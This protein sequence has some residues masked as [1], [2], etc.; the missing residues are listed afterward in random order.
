MEKPKSVTATQLTMSIGTSIIG[1]GILAFPRITVEYVRTGAPMAAICAMLLMMCG[2][3]V[4]AY[5]GNQYRER[6]IFEYAD[7]LVGQWIGRLLLVCIG[8]YFL[9]LAALASREFGEVVVTSVLQRTPIEVTV[10]VMVLMATVAC[11]SDIIVFARILTFYMPFVYFPALVIVVLSL[12]S[13]QSANLMPLLGMFYG[14]QVKS[15]FMSIMVVAALFT[16]YIIVGLIIPFM[17]QP[18]RAMRGTIVGIG[19]AGSLYIIL[20]FSTL[21]VFGIEEMDNL[22]WPT[23]ELAKTAALP[24]FYIERLDPIF[25]AVWV[26]AVFSAIFAAYYVAIQA[27]SHVFRLKNHR[28]LSI[29]A[30]PIIMLLAKLPP[31]IVSL[32]HVIKQVGVSGLCLTLGYPLLLL[33]AHVIKTARVKSSI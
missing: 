10:F 22:L 12:K 20:M 8:A 23:M 24:T 27:L 30:L 19:I 4:V 31:N 15:V 32:Y 11:R 28:G 17:Y 29:L 18:T 6:T 5:L 33:I 25:I 3:I 2:G 26:T 9:E 14:Q 21:S 13:A 1:V 7:E 16:N